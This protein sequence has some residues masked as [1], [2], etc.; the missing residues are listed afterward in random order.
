LVKFADEMPRGEDDSSHRSRVVPLRELLLSSPATHEAWR[1][2]FL[3]L[4]FS[5]AMPLSLIS[6]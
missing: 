5:T 2:Y 1:Q 6:Q 3:I 4:L